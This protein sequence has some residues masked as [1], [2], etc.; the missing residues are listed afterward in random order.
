MKKPS[1]LF[2]KKALESIGTLDQLDKLI[3]V[4]SPHAW[5]ILLTLLAL[6]T[7]I[8]IW[9]FVGS[10]P[11][12]VEGQGILVAEKGSIFAAVAPEGQAYIKKIM[13]RP[14]DQIK[15]DQIVAQL[16]NPQ[17]LQ[18]LEVSRAFL[19]KLQQQHTKLSKDAKVEIEKRKKELTNQN[20]VLKGIIKSETDNLKQTSKL[21][22]IRQQ[23]LKKGIE[24]RQNVLATL[25]DYYNTKRE[26]DNSK[27]QILQNTINKANFIDQWNERLR[28]LD[29]KVR[30]EQHK[31]DT[32]EAQLKTSK[33]VTSPITG[34]VTAIQK[35]IGD[36][37]KGGD[38]VVSI[39]TLG[40]GMDAIIFI[41]ARDGKRVRIDMSAFVTPAIIK[42]EEF[43]SIKGQVIQVSPYP[44]N[45]QVMRALLHNE[46]LV[47]QFSKEGAPIA[48]RIRLKADA[49]TYSGFAWTTS[50]GP[51]Q[52]ISPGNLATARIT[53][54]EQAPVSLVI[55][56]FRKL[57]GIE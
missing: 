34:I 19:I 29:L 55:P 7:I 8:V 21:L 2:R 28:Q 39:A 11:T 45:P 48:V 36:V 46:E 17:L 32:L 4:T 43:G 20:K 3:R 40:K 16:D 37:V 25:R 50:K 31:L 54:R 47:E 52:K 18:K 24:T 15:K 41:P 9:G 27:K 14:G 23:A 30:D 56:A 53:V 12:R 26:I 5:I 6:L 1:K 51:K 10:I 57:L 33:M 38:E 49:K 42:K 44:I 13:V 22:K 35:A